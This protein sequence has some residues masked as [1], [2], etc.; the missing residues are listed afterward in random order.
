MATRRVITFLLAA[1]FSYAA[2]AQTASVSRNLVLRKEPSKT[3]TALRSLEKHEEVEIVDPT[4]QNGY[5]HVETEDSLTGWVLARYVH[6][7]P[8]PGEQHAA[9]AA[10][11]STEAA[12]VSESWPKPDPNSGTF[13]LDG[14]TCGKDGSGDKRDKGTNIRKNRTDVPASYHAVTWNAIMD[15]PTPPAVPK[16]RENFTAE[17][18]QEIGKYEGAA[19]QTVGY[20]V[21]IKPQASNSESCNCGWHGE[22]ATDWHIAL[23]EK[24][25]D[26]EKTS[27]VV[28]P[29]PRIKKN[30]AGWTK[31]KLNPWLNS[32]QPVRISGWLLFD[33]QHKNHLNKYRNT[34]WEIH[35]ITKIEVWDDDA[36]KWV[37]LDKLSDGKS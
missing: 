14:K 28:E 3:A 34:L 35:P 33:P 21:A 1:F 8:N 32:D 24:P 5:L 4:P 29:T 22:K 25:G 20:V 17:Q 19:V 23:V 36:N 7:E 31:A 37:D 26:G 11:K 15:L 18:L 13:T 30:H 2:F 10:E 16:S 12:A 9:A 6:A 27:I